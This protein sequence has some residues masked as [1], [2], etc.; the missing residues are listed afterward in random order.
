[1]MLVTESETASKSRTSPVSWCELDGVA[2]AFAP[3]VGV[4][5]DVRGDG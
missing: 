2:D 4:V 1:M 5:G 3:A